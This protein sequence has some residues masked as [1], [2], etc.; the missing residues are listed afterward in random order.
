MA[1]SIMQFRYYDEKDS[2]NQPNFISLTK[3]WTGNIFSNF[4]PITQMTIQTLPGTKF[5]LNKNTNPIIV[6]PTGI[7]KINLEGLSEINSLTFN[8]S[9]LE[10]IKADENGYLIIDIVYGM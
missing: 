8:K 1:K 5:Y 9:S 2:K 3:L 10:T 7:Y 4:Y 6:G